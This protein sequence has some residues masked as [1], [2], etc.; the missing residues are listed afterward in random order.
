M[1]DVS[2]VIPV[3]NSGLL[4]KRCLDSILSQ[5]GNF[6]YEVL[7]VDDGSID[8]SS[9]VIEEYNNPCFSLIHQQNA[10]P[11]KAR[12][13]GIELASGK[14][15]AFID[16]DDYWASMFIDR[17]VTFLQEHQDCVAASCGQRHQTV[18][19]SNIAPTD[20]EKYKEPFVIDD[21]FSINLYWDY[22]CT[23]SMMARADVVKST[24]GQ[25]SDLRITEDLEFWALLATKGK[26][27]FIPEVFFTSDGMDTILGRDGWL[28]KMQVRWN[29]APTIDNWQKR[30]IK[31]SSSLEGSDAFKRARGVISRNLT[32][33]QLLSGRFDVARR[34]ACLYGAYFTKDKIGRLMNLC[35]YSACLWNAMCL[36]L[37]YREYHRFK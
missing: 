34:E 12:N 29:N 9:E 4:I 8:N 36:I 37:R 2:I 15:I 30:L 31:N 18:S 16:S 21:F 28:K 20:I 23:G 24:G 13:K 10:G 5:K 25:R 26:W 33:C 1:I 7:L 11:A 6:T 32:Y 3:Y 27:G 35:K 19:G 14:Y 22:V 17:M